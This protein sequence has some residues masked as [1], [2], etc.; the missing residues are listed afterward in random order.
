MRTVFGMI[1]KNNSE[2]V[3]VALEIFKSHPVVDVRVPAG[4]KMSTKGLTMGILRWKELLPIIAAAIEAF[5]MQLADPESDF[6]K[7]IGQ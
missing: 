3:V 6:A 5:E 2:N 7:E 4:E 1:K